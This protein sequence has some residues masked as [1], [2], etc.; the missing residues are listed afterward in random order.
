MTIQSPEKRAAQRAAHYEANRPRIREAQKAYIDKDRDAHRAYC[1]D[2]YH[3]HK[4]ENRD[5]DRL[6]SKEWYERNKDRAIA[7]VI[8]RRVATE[9]QRCTCCS[10][11]VFTGIY[12]FSREA[13]LHVDHI[14]PLSKNGIHCQLNLQ[15]LSPKANLSKG[16][17][18]DGVSGVGI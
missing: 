5:A 18:W 6:R 12:A 16:A 10:D 9:D 11:E 17:S 2:Y 13:G 14:R 8:K 3:A 15:L 7:K 4:D 1:R